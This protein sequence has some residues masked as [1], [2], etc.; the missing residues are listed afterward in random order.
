MKAR[1]RRDRVFCPLPLEWLWNI[2]SP[3]R[4]H[5]CSPHNPGIHGKWR[6]NS[7][8]PGFWWRYQED[9][10]KVKHLLR[11]RLPWRL[12]PPFPPDRQRG[13]PSPYLHFQPIEDPRCCRSLLLQWLMKSSLSEN[14]RAPALS[15]S[16]KSLH[17]QKSHSVYLH[18]PLSRDLRL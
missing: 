7:N 8:L 10:R 1:S 15:S 9:G 2:C 4:C 16:D 14:Q 13:L 17:P 5:Q 18:N 12:L 6:W 3:R 11:G